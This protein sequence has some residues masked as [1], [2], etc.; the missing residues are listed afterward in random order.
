MNKL[1]F[2]II[3]PVVKAILASPLHGLMSRNTIVIEFRGRK[4]GRLLSTPVSYVATDKE[5]HCFTSPAFPWWRNL[6]TGESVTLLL[7][8]KRRTASTERRHQRSGHHGSCADGIF[9]CGTE[10]RGAFRRPP[11]L[12]R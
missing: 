12:R 7:R 6:L 5:I 2:R 11:H 9:D 3:N 1:F 4:S 8:G 10:G